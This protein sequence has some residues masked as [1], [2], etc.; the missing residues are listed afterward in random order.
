MI[1]PHQ[2]IGLATATAVSVVLAIGSR[3]IY[4]LASRWLEENAWTP[5]LAPTLALAAALTATLAPTWQLEG[6]IAAGSTLAAVLVLLVA[7]KSARGS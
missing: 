7:A 2:F 5:R 1:K 6:T 3:L 4:S